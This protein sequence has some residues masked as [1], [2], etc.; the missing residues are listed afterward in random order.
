MW[1][2]VWFFVVI[3]ALATR[4]DIHLTQLLSQFIVFSDEAMQPPHFPSLEQD[5]DTQSRNGLLSSAEHSQSRVQKAR[6]LLRAMA[7]QC[8]DFASAYCDDMLKQLRKHL[9][10]LADKADS[11]ARAAHWMSAYNLLERQK[12][13]FKRSHFAALRDILQDAI[14]APLR[15]RLSDTANASGGAL[16]FSPDASLS[17]LDFSEMDRKVLLDR[18][19]RP[20]NQQFDE[21]LAPL[22]A[23]CG[24][25]FSIEEPEISHNPFR[26]ENFVRALM[27]GWDNARLDEHA[28]DDL[29]LSITPQSFYPLNELYTQLNDMMIR[30][31]VAPKL[32]LRI[33]KARDTGVEDFAPSTRSGG[34]FSSGSGSGGGGTSANG[35]G[36]AGT[37]GGTGSGAAG[38]SRAGMN[39]SPA[40]RA[41][42]GDYP[43][44]GDTAIRNTW[45]TGA[46]SP[47]ILRIGHSAKQ[48]LGK[49]SN[50]LRRPVFGTR[51]DVDHLL[52]PSLGG[53]P[54]EAP[55]ADE[56]FLGFLN[57][58]QAQ[59]IEPDHFPKL[60]TD[61]QVGAAVEEQKNVLRSMSESAEVQ[62]AP[63]LDRG[64]VDALAEVF[65][66]VFRDEAIPSQ[67]K[68][69]IGR[70]QI[71]VLKAAMIDREF[72]F[73]PDHPA[74]K[75]VDSLARASIA[76]TPDKGVA[77]PL[78]GKIE[79]TVTRVLTEFEEDLN[80]FAQLLQDFEHFL[81]ENEQQ[82]AARI[83]PQTNDAVSTEQLELAMRM[84]DEFVHTRVG[85]K[86]VTP[87]L[88]PFLT[89]Q[90][91]EVLGHAWL[92]REAEPDI[93]DRAVETM[94]QLIWTTQPKVTVQDRRQLVSILPAMVRNL[95]GALD[96]IGWNGQERAEF[97]RDLIDTHTRL[98]RAGAAAGQ[99][100]EQKDNHA[101]AADAAIELLDR[102]RAGS[103]SNA[104]DDFDRRAKE[105]ARGTWF[106]VYTA[107]G[108]ARRYRLTW[109]SP[110]RTRLLF[111][112]RDGYEAFVK[113]EAEVGQ[114][115][116]SGR[117]QVIDSGPIIG[118]ALDELMKEPDS[119]IA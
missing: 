78:Y 53:L 93:W 119:E 118:R 70:M 87:L 25:V 63:E 64:T 16:N 61:T 43:D 20:L 58:L 76:W 8:S 56:A 55:R 94:D 3:A 30:A 98:V 38:E 60:E 54:I 29:V 109:V 69:L 114:L 95:N 28:T 22:T 117:M 26:P 68:V 81:F 103:V 33:K 112:N 62:R 42:A 47:S 21:S 97:T 40:A 17:L 82:L 5:F 79:G 44:S 15:N 83:E 100:A 36:G 37:G 111:T 1:L 19:A 48:F 101:H 32:K 51:A 11:S 10:D 84:A 7:A 31:G 50:L 90:W 59:A 13:A 92:N 89:T 113:N 4:K 74:R 23:R 46:F 35:E 2:L 34:A 73:R 45:D 65:D 106:E 71:P 57:E 24:I 88:A 80:L 107:L 85:S 6:V 41:L 96:Q 39:A 27:L 14:D 115:L 18:V 77:D 66:Y 99:A 52:E 91:R 67:L 105:L 75:L 116:R 102:R 110:M 104:A 108:E 86:D 9:F 12:E 72:F 49:L